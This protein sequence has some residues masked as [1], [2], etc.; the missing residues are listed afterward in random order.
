MARGNF[1]DV[2]LCMALQIRSPGTA[3]NDAL[4]PKGQNCW[5]KSKSAVA[6]KSNGDRNND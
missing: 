5:A 6:Y 1:F 2:S 3:A 4:L